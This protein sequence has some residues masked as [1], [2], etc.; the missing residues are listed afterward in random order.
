MSAQ[1]NNP[2]LTKI[3]FEPQF[4]EN[5]FF[6][7]VTDIEPIV[8]EHYMVFSKDCYPSLADCS[9]DIS[10]FLETSFANKVYKPYAFFERGRASFCTSMN[11]VQHGHG[12]LV[13]SFL[14]NMSDLFP[15]G[16][17]E[18]YDSLKVAYSNINCDGQYLIWGN[19]GKEFHVLQNIE[20]LPK[21]IIRTTIKSRFDI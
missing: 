6:G 14:Q 12:H 16:K 8:P 15:Y 18:T 17:V 1:T 13:P 19:I 5:E 20:L 3:I 2:F 4:I 10:M 21:R 9:N 7:V 11:G